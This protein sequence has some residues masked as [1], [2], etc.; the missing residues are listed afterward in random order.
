M[1]GNVVFGQLVVGPAGSGKTTY[2]H[3]MADYLRQLGRTVITVNI[4]PANDVLPYEPTIDIS[5]LITLSDAMESMSLGPNG[6][7]LYCMDF[8]DHN[9]DWFCDEL[10][11]AVK[12]STDGKESAI[13][14]VL[15]DSPG[16]IE[17]YTN[18]GSLKSVLNK[19]NSLS[20]RNTFADESEKS[21][22]KSSDENVLDLRL[23]CVNIVDSHYTNEASKFISVAINCLQSMIH[24]EMPHISVLSKV[25][26]IQKYA[27]TDFG[28]DFYCDLLDL[29]YLV[30]KMN[31]QN[32]PFLAKYQKLTAAL[33]GVIEDYSLLSFIPLDVNNAKSVIRVLKSCDRANGYYLTDLNEEE[34]LHNYFRGNGS[35][36][37]QNSKYE[38]LLEKVID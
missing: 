2:C 9:F 24:L 6:G 11:A 14:Y 10:R 19:L 8:L 16:Q 27:K 12:T 26:L 22:D 23:V 32:D 37:F 20:K 34:L 30:D 29:N 1:S 18:N 33:A 7:L 21:S 28:L 31:E 17:L 38:E 25:D 13:P 3:V 4:D 36:D 15:V 35:A 5:K